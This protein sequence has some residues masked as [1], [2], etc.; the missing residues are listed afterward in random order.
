[1]RASIRTADEATV[2]L[3]DGLIIFWLALWIVVGAWSGYTIWQLSDLGDTVTNSGLALHSTGEALQTLGELPVVGA[4]PSDLG[5]E[6]VSTAEDIAGR[7][8]D[9]QAQLR[10]LSL[11]LGLS[12]MLMP[13]TPVLGLYLPLRLARRR[14]LLDVRRGLAEDGWDPLLERYLAERALDHLPYAAVRDISDD[15][16]RDIADGR[17]HA[18]ARAEIARMG[19]RP[20]KET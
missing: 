13:T 3:L 1:M 5:D 7:G 16:W 10:Q 18:L 8:Q 12:I 14:E 15:P 6:V 11:T 9:V 2:R 19:L 20:P 17:G 4:E